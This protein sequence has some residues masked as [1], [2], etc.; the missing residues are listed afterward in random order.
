MVKEQQ[1]N[2]VPQNTKEERHSRSKPAK[3][4]ATEIKHGGSG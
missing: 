3:Q 2:S 4:N 1:K